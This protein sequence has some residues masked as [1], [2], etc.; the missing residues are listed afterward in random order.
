MY[1][2]TRFIINILIGTLCACVFSRRARATNCWCPQP[3]LLHGRNRIHS[4]CYH[5]NQIVYLL[6]FFLGWLKISTTNS[7]MLQCS[8]YLEKS[9]SEV[10]TRNPNHLIIAEISFHRIVAESTE[11]K[12]CCLVMYV[13]YYFYPSVMVWVRVCFFLPKRKLL[14]PFFHRKLVRWKIEIEK[15]AANRYITFLDTFISMP[16]FRK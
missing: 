2:I 10:G 9:E 7:M 3:L 6:F 12:L 1:A 15:K 11:E 14:L 8:E 5:Y 13:I 16:S 4:P